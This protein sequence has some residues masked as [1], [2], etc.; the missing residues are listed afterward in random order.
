MKL[1]PG[2]RALDVATGRGAVLFA[3]AEQVGP[4]GFVIGI[5]LAQQMVQETAADLRKRQIPNAAVQLMDAE[6]LAFASASFDAVLCSHALPLFPQGERA[7]AEFHRVLR[8]GGKVGICMPEGGDER[9]LWYTHL[10]FTYCHIYHLSTA[11]V[12]RILDTA[13]V[14][15]LLREAG[16][17][18]ISV[19]SQ[20]HAFVYATVQEWWE[21][22]WTDAARFPLEEMP[23][24]VLEQF[25]TEVFEHLASFKQSDGLAYRRKASLL[26]G[27]KSAVATEKENVLL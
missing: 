26:V 1:S 2:T 18:E 8:P 7:L 17:V 25:R 4:A 24:A 9:W 19:A 6:H 23:P 3:A 27:T 10:I 22:Q 11:W 5:D 15:R 16:F 12:P 14:T 13:E 21:A 20:E